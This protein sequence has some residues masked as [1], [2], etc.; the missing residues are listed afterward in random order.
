MAY[1]NPRL[2][3]ALRITYEKLKHSPL[4]SWGHLGACNCGHLA[5]AVTRQ[6]AQE[7]HK[8]ALR[9]AGDWGEVVVEYCPQSRLPVDHILTQLYDLGLTARDIEHFEDLSDPQVLAEV[10]ESGVYLTRNDKDHVMRYIQGWITVLE[11]A[12]FQA[13]SEPLPPLRKAS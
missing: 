3:Q 13:S 7:I 5:Q 10:V 4:Y 2:I 6:S 12:L 8:A 9:R 1:A 11:K